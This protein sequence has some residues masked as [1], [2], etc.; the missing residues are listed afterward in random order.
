VRDDVF[1]K[2]VSDLAAFHA[3]QQVRKNSLPAAPDKYE[4]KLPP[5]FQAPQGV[6]FEFDKNDALLAKSRELAHKRGMDQETYSDF[7]GLYAASKISEQQQLA[8]A[9][10]A[11]MAKLGSAAQ[12]RIDA[13]DTWLHARVGTK[14]DII[15]NQLRNF[16]VATMIEAFEEVIRQFSHQ[17][18]AEFSQ[19]GRQQQDN[20][21]KIPGYETMSFVQRRAAQD[22]AAGR[23]I[24][25][26]GRVAAGGR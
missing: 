8:T 14:A 22:A 12:G 24:A 21:G 26:T 5:D 1:G 17:G 19:S 9:R 3:E 2:R 23:V 20:S 18:G 10:G 11:E 7:L 25:P 13:V 6:T 16:P 4:I 15:V